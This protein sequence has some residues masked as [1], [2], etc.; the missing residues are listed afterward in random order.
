MWARALAG[1]VPGFFLA[2]GLVGLVGWSLPGPWTAALV[3][4][5]VVFFPLW[6]GLAAGAFFFRDGLRAWL[7]LGGLAVASL[8]LLRGLQVAGWVM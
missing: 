4:G 5:L 6:M 1:A 8:A 3:P 2:A 7:W